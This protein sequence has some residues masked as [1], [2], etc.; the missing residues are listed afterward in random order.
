MQNF[1][2]LSFLETSRNF[3]EPWILPGSDHFLVY[4]AS[5]YLN[6]EFCLKNGKCHVFNVF[7]YHLFQNPKITRDIKKYKIF[8]FLRQNS[9]YMT[10]IKLNQ[11]P[12]CQNWQKNCNFQAI[13]RVLENFWKFPGMVKYLYSVFRIKFLDMN[14]QCS[15]EGCHRSCTFSYNISQILKLMCMFVKPQCLKRI[16]DEVYITSYK[17]LQDKRICNG[18]SKCIF[19]ENLI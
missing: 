12:I 2:I 10:K 16:L 5:I 8:P 7:R 17:L 3:L 18:I 15:R 4:W 14:Q 19:H 1:K 13:S 9:W 6:F 11:C